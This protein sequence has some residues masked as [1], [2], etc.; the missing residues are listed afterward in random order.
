HPRRRRG[1]E[2]F[3]EE[4]PQRLALPDLDVPRA[5]V[6]DEHEAKRMLR[7]LPGRYRLAQRGTDPDD[8][9]DLRLEIEPSRRA[10]ARHIPVRVRRELPAGSAAPVTGD[11]A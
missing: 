7:E 8:E 9:A 5:P 6:I 2:R 11:H 3:R 10:E 4:R 1:G